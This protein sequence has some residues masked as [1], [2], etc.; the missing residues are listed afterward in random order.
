M[1]FINDNEEIKN[2]IRIYSFSIIIILINF[3]AFPYASK[4]DNF[5][6]FLVRL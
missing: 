6:F 1:N 5:I 4:Q 2:V 3:V